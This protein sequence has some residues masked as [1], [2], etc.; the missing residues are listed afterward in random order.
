MK[1]PTATVVL[2]SAALLFVLW[3]QT[4]EP[5]VPLKPSH[6]ANLAA[7][8]VELGRIVDWVTGQVPGLCQESTGMP[9]GSREHDDCL[10]ASKSREPICRR[11]MA[12]RFP[13][14]IGTERTFRDLSITM[15][16]CLVQQSRVLEESRVKS[17]NFE[18]GVRTVNM[19]VSSALHS[20]TLSNYY[21]RFFQSHRFG[22]ALV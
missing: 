12:D 14:M 19:A 21:V 9:E 6:I 8:P 16:D 20:S 10:D 7:Q 11:A 3:D 5:P 13:G 4:R 18:M 22:L 1:F 17:Q 15:M 2:V